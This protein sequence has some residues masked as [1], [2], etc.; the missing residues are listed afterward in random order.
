MHLRTAV[1]LRKLRVK[2]EG[3][4]GGKLGVLRG[5][6]LSTVSAAV[7][8]FNCKSPIPKVDAKNF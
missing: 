8:D 1:S 3:K 7:W 5:P 4:L 2:F 6:H